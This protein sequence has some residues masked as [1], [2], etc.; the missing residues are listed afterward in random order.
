MDKLELAA[1]CEQA[2]LNKLNDY[3][4]ALER[5]SQYSGSDRLDDAEKLLNCAAALRA[6]DEG[7]KS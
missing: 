1:R 5:R 6:R 4:V 3:L 2:A 7:G